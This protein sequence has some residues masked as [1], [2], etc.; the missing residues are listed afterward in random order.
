MK[1]KVILKAKETAAT[2]SEFHNLFRPIVPSIDRIG[3]VAQVISA[4]TEAI[5]IWHLTQSEMAGASKVVAILVSIIATILVVSILELGGRKF[6]Q[7]LTR[8]LVWKQLKNGWYIALFS[9]VAFITIGIAVMSFRLSTNG[10]HHAFVS[11]VSVVSTI[12]DVALKQDYREATKDLTKEFDQELDLLKTNHEALTK[13]KM[14]KFQSRIDEGRAKI[15]RYERKFAAGEK[16]AKSQADKHRKAVNALE[17]KKADALIVLQEQFVKKTDAWMARRNKAKA[18]EKSKLEKQTLIAQQAAD[19]T[20]ASKS[21]DAN[22]WGSLFSFLVGF[23]VILAFIC[24][25]TVEI[26]RR[27]CGIQV[28]YEE[29]SEDLSTLEIFWKGLNQRCST[30]FRTKAERFARIAPDTSSRSIGFD[31]PK[32]IATGFSKPMMG[33]ENDFIE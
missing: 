1:Q 25:I 6:L 5:T 7:V 21:K 2:N 22:F 19:K 28:A 30:F 9:I 10:I 8:T 27:G 32:P 24:I 14:E 18:A 31:Y 4:L 11:N 13:S 12:D 26:Y 15:N 29:E 16:W 23:S 20:H 3:K 17:V 33:E